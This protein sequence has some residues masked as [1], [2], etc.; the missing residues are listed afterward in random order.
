MAQP[1]KCERCGCADDRHDG[2]THTADEC[3]SNIEMRVHA[4][5]LR[6][7]TLINTVYEIKE[8]K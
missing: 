2:E 4:V 6:L 1:I 3:M 8:A 5:E 7:R